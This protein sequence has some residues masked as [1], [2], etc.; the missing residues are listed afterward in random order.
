MIPEKTKYN[1]IK[2]KKYSKKKQK[3]VKENSKKKKREKIYL[4]GECY[5]KSDGNFKKI[6]YFWYEKIFEEKQNT[7]NEK[8]KRK[9]L[10]EKRKINSV[11]YNLII[12]YLLYTFFF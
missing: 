11:F 6:G 3:E 9:R 5:L 8:N 12:Q 1:K 10:N 7:S 4:S 2:S